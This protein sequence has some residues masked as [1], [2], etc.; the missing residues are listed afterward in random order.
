LGQRRGIKG[1]QRT[2]IAITAEAKINDA[3]AE[4]QCSTLLLQAGI[5]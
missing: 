1:E 3:I 4:Q 2:T 5:E